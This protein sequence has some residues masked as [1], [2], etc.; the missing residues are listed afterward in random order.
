MPLYFVRRLIG[1]GGQLEVNDGDA[2]IV[3]AADPIA[4]RAAAGEGRIGGSAAWADAFCIELD[5]PGL[6]GNGGILR[7]QSTSELPSSWNL[8]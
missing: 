1:R 4:A 5:E 7:F 8:N 6:M 2:A 3:A